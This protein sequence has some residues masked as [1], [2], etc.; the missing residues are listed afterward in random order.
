MKGPATIE[1]GGS[2]R[3]L[4]QQ[5]IGR[6]HH[7]LSPRN[8]GARESPSQGFKEVENLLQCLQILTK[9]K[10]NLVGTIEW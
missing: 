10:L 6:R 4:K 3:S 7:P 8:G 5:G 1:N 2:R 9:S